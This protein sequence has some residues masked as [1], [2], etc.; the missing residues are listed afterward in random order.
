M[1]KILVLVCTL[2]CLA[3]LAATVVASDAPATEPAT[4]GET[5]SAIEQDLDLI[6]VPDLF[7]PEPLARSCSCTDDSQCEAVCLDGGRCMGGE[8]A[9]FAGS[10][11][12]GPPGGGSGGPGGGCG[13]CT[14]N[15]DCLSCGPEYICPSWGE[16]AAI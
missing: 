16:C 12:C 15:D 14:S 8:C 11:M 9:C 3:A 10:P 13:S 6:D 1:K 5:P 4:H 7:T 2:S